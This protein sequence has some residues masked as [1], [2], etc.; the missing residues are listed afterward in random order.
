[1]A[2]GNAI[3]MERT[4]PESLDVVMGKRPSSLAG[5]PQPVPQPGGAQATPQPGTPA[6]TPAAT[7]APSATPSITP[8]TLDDLLRQAQQ[9]SNATQQ[10]LDRLRAILEQIQRQLSQP[11]QQAPR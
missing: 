3:S 11:Q 8:G 6:P 2:N 1:V 9:S 7:P 4:F 5:G 10:E